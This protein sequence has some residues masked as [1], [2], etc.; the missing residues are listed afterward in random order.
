MTGVWFLAGAGMDVFPFHHCIQ[1][2][3]VAH[4]ASYPIGNGGSFP[5]GKAA[6]TQS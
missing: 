4:P 3:S 5:R 6:S 1:T 2:G